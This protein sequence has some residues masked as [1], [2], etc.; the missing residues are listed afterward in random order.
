MEHYSPS[1]FRKLADCPQQYKYRYIDKQHEGTKEALV[2]G[3]AMDEAINSIHFHI[4]NP[5]LPA[6]PET[7]LFQSIEF[8][9][10]TYGDEMT[11][12]QWDAVDELAARC[13]EQDVF[14]EYQELVDFKVRGVQHD[15]VLRI[16][17]I[18]RR[19]IGITDLIAERAVMDQ[20]DHYESA[21]IIDVK[22]A[23]RS[24]QRPSYAHRFQLAFYAL[25]WMCMQGT[26]V[27]P[28]CEIRAL[29]KNKKMLWQ[30]LPANITEDDL[31]HVVA[32]ARNHDRMVKAQHFPVNRDSKFC[33]SK[34]CSF[35]KRCHDEHGARLSD[36][37]A[38]CVRG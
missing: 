28:Q 5:S 36:T 17:G 26:N 35:Y 34:N 23:G 38:Q 6:K 20:S 14:S 32:V 30:V 2:F 24:M 15:M 3:T 18:D 7:Y 33:T 25:A 13:V 22:T 31:A 8:S 11:P 12:E 1:Q 29:I 19:I 37:L 10:A 27:I 4:Q 21:L 9:R 16:Y